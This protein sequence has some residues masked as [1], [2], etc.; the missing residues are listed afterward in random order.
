LFSLQDGVESNPTLA[1][2]SNLLYQDSTPEEIADRLKD[3]GNEA[4]K[5]G[6]KYYN[7]AIKHYSE[8]I[9]QKCS[10]N[11]LQSI[12]FSNRAAVNLMMGNEFHYLLE[13]S[14][15]ISFVQ[16]TTA[17]CWKTVKKRSSSILRTSKLTGELRKQLFH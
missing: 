17:R 4:L 13:L 15:D 14:I 7:D 1:A 11:K 8:G 3:K 5:R 9:A 10:D 16:E 2:I 6:K 12:L